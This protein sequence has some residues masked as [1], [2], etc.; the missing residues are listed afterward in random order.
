MIRKMLSKDK[1]LNH[2]LNTQKLQIFVK[3]M[4]ILKVK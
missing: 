2:L 1:V 4:S 3:L